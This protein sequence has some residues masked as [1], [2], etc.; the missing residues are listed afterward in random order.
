MNARYY[1]RSR[2]CC[3]ARW[4]FYMQTAGHNAPVSSWYLWL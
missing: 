2:Y 1:A 3:C 4:R